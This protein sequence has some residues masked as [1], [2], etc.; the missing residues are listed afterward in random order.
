[1]KSRLAACFVLW[2]VFFFGILPP[3]LPAQEVDKGVEKTVEKPKD[4]EPEKGP[5]EKLITLDFNNVELPVFV[6][7]ISE[8]TGKNFIIDEKVKGKVTI[9]SPSKIPV[10]RAYDVFLSVLELKGF[11]VVSTDDVFQIVPL[12]EVPPDRNVHVYTLENTP[13]EDMAK[14]LLGLASKAAT[15]PRRGGKSGGELTGTVQILSDKTTNTL[16]I[17]ATDEDYEVLKKVIQQLDMKRRQVFVEAVVLEMAADKFRELGTDLG[18]VFGYTTN[19]GSL[20]AIGGFNQNPNDLIDLVKVPGVEVGTVN[21]RALLRALQS[22][23]EVNILSTPQILTSDNQKAEIVVA[24]NVPFP[25]SQSQTVGGNVQTTIERKDVGIILRLTPQV[26]ENDLVKLDVY[27]EISS[28]VETAQ[29]VGT[30]VLGPTTN[31]RSANTTIIVRH[32]Q[33]VVIGGLIRDNIVITQRKIPLLGDIPLLGWLFKFQSKRFEKTNLLIFL[34][35]HIVR[36][37]AD[38]D[39]IR[40][41]KTDGAATFIEDQRLVGGES[42]VNLFKAMVNVPE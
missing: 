17:T 1:M 8:L 32:A 2:A 9:F 37:S 19:D 42:R 23:S 3:P 12:A 28:V 22:S 6:K 13:A 41:S 38:L 14:V 18:A 15:P 26:L 20:A 25:G 5:K 31:K 4:K 40:R 35:P 27:Q 36:E 24:Q 29:T 33:T 16:I 21:I 11:T 39:E 7:F 30:V 10:V 34:T